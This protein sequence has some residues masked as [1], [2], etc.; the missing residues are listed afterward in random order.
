MRGVASINTTSD[1]GLDGT[2]LDNSDDLVGEST[3]SLE[4]SSP[5][6]CVVARESILGCDVH[7]IDSLN[8]DN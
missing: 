2:T 8:F 6:E 1:V 5:D 3:S 7:D 4:P